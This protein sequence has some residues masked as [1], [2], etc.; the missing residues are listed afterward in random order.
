M[1]NIFKGKMEKLWFLTK[2]PEKVSSDLMNF[3]ENAGCIVELLVIRI[4]IHAMIINKIM[5]IRQE[6]ETS[7]GRCFLS[8]SACLCPLH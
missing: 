4:S 6:K 5:Q 1:S 2:K 7:K 3:N 8:Q